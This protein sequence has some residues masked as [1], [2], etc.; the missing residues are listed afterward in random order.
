MTSM[1]GDLASDFWGHHH[2]PRISSWCTFITTL[3]LHWT[4]F[5]L[6][7][8]HRINFLCF[9]ARSRTYSSFSHR[10]PKDFVGGSSPAIGRGRTNLNTQWLLKHPCANCWW[11]QLLMGLTSPQPDPA[12]KLLKY[13]AA[14]PCKVPFEAGMRQ[15]SNLLDRHLLQKR[16]VEGGARARVSKGSQVAG[17]WA[18]KDS[19]TKKK[20]KTSIARIFSVWDQKDTSC[21]NKKKRQGL[22]YVG[23]TYVDVSYDFGGDPK[24]SDIRVLK[25]V[26]EWGS[27]ILGKTRH[28]INMI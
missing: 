17:N 3:A 16:N 6:G 13:P 23:M 27:P 26:V 25:P 10:T 8:A 1:G 7:S 21:P 18:T 12:C 19:K 2:P 11:I 24:S 28:P 5:N 14:L 9:L 4:P 15:L 22:E 20:Q